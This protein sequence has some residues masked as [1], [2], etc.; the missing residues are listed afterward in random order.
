[1]DPAEP[2]PR[3]VAR[4]CFDNAMARSDRARER[5]ED[6]AQ[7]ITAFSESQK[8]KVGIRVEKGRDGFGFWNE[9]E[10]PP[11]IISVIVGEVVYNLRAALD[12]LIYSLA[13]LDSG[14]HQVKTQFPITDTPKVFREQR[15]GFLRGVSDEHVEKV[16]EFQ[17]FAG[18]KWSATLRNLSNQD[19]HWALAVT[20]TAHAGT[21]EIDPP[22][23][24]PMT[25]EYVEAFQA[26][27]VKITHDPSID[28]TF[29][30]GPPVVQGLHSLEAG[31][32][33][34]LRSFE[35]DMSA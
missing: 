12:Y 14:Q 1:M 33:D 31:V 3:E 13:W 10:G 25:D 29:A 2:D 28:V 34:V 32:R 18:C 17:P 7:R 9:I 22:I 27:R 19:K 21:I 23:P 24:S 20:S 6:L 8:D 11:R 30:N 35:Q 4:F 5:L 16:R 15:L 26:G